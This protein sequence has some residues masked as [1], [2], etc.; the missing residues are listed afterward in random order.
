MSTGASRS[1]ASSHLDQRRAGATAR[2]MLD[3]RRGA[4]LERAG[5]ENAPPVCN[6]ISHAGSGRS[7]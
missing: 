3:R 1:A 6:V 2:E 7:G 4:A 5:C